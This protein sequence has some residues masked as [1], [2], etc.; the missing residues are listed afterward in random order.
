[1]AEKGIDLIGPL[2]E[3]KKPS[4]DVLK[5][6]GVSAEFYPQAFSYDPS[7][8]SYRCPAGQRL[9]FETEERQA[10]W[11]KRR[12]RARRADCR[13]CPFQSQ[14]CPGTKKG[15][16][17]LRMEKTAQ[18]AAFEAKMQSEQAQQIYKERAGVAEFPNAWIKEKIGLRQFRLR[19][20][21]KVGLEVL[22]ACLT[23]NICQ[24]IRLCWRPQR[25]AHA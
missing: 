23:Y 3:R 8:D 25:L 18:L 11:V 21:I 5:R 6:N 13:R 9:S 1:M 24:W 17:L 7:S 15:R 4:W 20:L 14:C 12:Y 19:G 22:W 10:G 16:S 2:V